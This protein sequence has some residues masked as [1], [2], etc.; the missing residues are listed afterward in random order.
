M[1]IVCLNLQYIFLFQ[2]RKY[3]FM[4]ILNI[5]KINITMIV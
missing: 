2:V 5:D 3:I 1:L 4:L